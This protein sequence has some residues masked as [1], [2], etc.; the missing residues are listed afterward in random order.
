MRKSAWAGLYA[1]GRGLRI[2][3]LHYFYAAVHP[4]AAWVKIDR[5]FLKKG[6]QICDAPG[7]ALATTYTDNGL[8]R[9]RGRK[10]ARTAIKN[11][12]GFLSRRVVIEVAVIVARMR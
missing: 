8:K 4:S 6:I 11:P 5:Y 7:R 12:A 9:S 3:G 2:Y 10:P 1:F